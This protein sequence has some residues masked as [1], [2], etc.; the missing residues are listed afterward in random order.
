MAATTV[1]ACAAAG[2]VAR[3][4]R[5]EGWIAFVLIMSVGVVLAATLTP[6]NG[7]F[8]EQHRPL[9]QCDFSRISPAHLSTYLH[10]GEPG[11][12][13]ILF[14]PLGLAI[15][16]LGRSGATARLLVAAA[17]LPPV[18][19]GVQS[20]LPMFGRGC[21]SADVVD[22]LLGLGIGFALGALLSVIRSSR[23]RRH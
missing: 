6:V 19:E 22:N 11:L 2:R 18:I 3:R 1:I 7:Q 16:L 10:A 14:A 23:T 21:E 4:V 13:V 9:G 20:L 12:N 8:R 15:G 17:A 5:T